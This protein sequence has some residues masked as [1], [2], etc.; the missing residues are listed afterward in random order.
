MNGSHSSLRAMQRRF[1]KGLG[2]GESP[3]HPCP[4]HP[5]LDDVAAGSLDRA[6]GNGIAAVR[7]LVMNVV[8]VA[9][10]IALDLLQPGTAGGGQVALLGQ[11]LQPADH[12]GPHSAQ[13]PRDQPFHLLEHH[14]AAGSW[15]QCTASHRY[16][17]AY[18]CRGTSRRGMGR[19][20]CP[21]GSRNRA[22]IIASLGKLL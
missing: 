17:V 21:A 9:V 1:N 4:F 14:G 18:F 3:V 8:A 7:Y 13:Q 20:G 6:R 11:R 12:P 10:E 2:A 19:L 22:S 5:V 15:N 16:P